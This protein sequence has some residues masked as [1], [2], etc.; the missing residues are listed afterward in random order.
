MQLKTSC[1][2]AAA[3]SWLSRRSSVRRRRPVQPNSVAHDIE[4]KFPG[5]YAVAT[6]DVNKD[7]KLDV[8]G[9][10]QRVQE[11]AWYENP[12][13]ARH[14]MVEG[15]AGLVNFAAIDLDGDGIPEVA[16]TRT[17]SPCRQP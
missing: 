11:V 7:G 2:A 6:V 17:H 10:S 15:M 3:G 16:V 4:P 12:T 13:W 14:V 1:T 8:I 5:G 9:V